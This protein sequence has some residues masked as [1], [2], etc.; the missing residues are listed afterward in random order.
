MGRRRAQ[1][2][3]PNR[4]HANVIACCTRPACSGWTHKGRQRWCACR[5]CYHPACRHTSL[6]P[7]NPASLSPNSSP[8]SLRSTE[9]SPGSHASESRVA[10]NANLKAAASGNGS[11]SCGPSGGHTMID[12][13]ASTT[14]GGLSWTPDPLPTDVAQPMS[15]TS[16]ARRNISVGRQEPRPCRSMWEVSPTG[17]CCWERPMAVRPGREWPSAPERRAELLRA[18]L[19][20]H[21]IDRLPFCGGACRPRVRGTERA[22]R[23]H[24]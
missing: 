3:G 4:L 17:A 8:F 22:E 20:Q 16:R 1:A 6:S 10:T 21:G 14:D 7:A 13:I 11:F 18:V 2:T 15:P 23:S 19:L 12:V 5:T 9:R 24:V